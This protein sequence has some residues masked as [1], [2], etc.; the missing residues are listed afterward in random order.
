MDRTI[1]CTDCGELLSNE[2]DA[3]QKCRSSKR[4]VCMGFSDKVSFHEQLRGK[5]K[6]EGTK[7]PVKEFIYG[8]E[9]KISNNTWV[10]KT[11]IIDRENNQYV[12]IIKDKDTGE[13]IHECKEPLTDHFNHGSAKF[14]KQK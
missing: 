10:D 2:S 13:I 4:T 9:K 1:K 14:K 6:K 7:K 3:C 8:D 12:E 5:A 11:R